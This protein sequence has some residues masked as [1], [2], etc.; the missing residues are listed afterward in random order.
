MFKNGS[1][2]LG[3]RPGVVQGWVPVKTGDMPDRTHALLLRGVNVGGR[4]RLPM[5]ELSALVSQLGGQHVKTYI[6]SGN[7]VCG[8]S[9]EAAQALPAALA[10][11]I[12][13]RFGF[14]SPVV[15]RATAELEGAVAAWPWEVPEEERYLYFLADLPAPERVAAL[16]PKRSP[17]DRFAVIGRDLHAHLPGSVA[18]TKLT[19]DWL[20]RQLKTVSTARNWR[21]TL[22]ILDLLRA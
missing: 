14:R 6:Q 17:G 10:E 2:S 12:E 1:L 3:A 4:N 5:A 20:D 8:L 21:T 13:A 11:Q 15:M 19:N 16:D 9:A 22:A 18:N 7:V